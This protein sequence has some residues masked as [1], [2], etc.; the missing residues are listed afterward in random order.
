MLEVLSRTETG[1][2]SESA[3]HGGLGI[4]AFAALVDRLGPFAAAVG[5]SLAHLA[6][7]GGAGASEADRSAVGPAERRTPTALA[8]LRSGIEQVD[9]RIIELIGRRVEL[10]RGA[11][12]VKREAGL[13]V[14]DE[15][16]EHDVLARVR[17]LATSAGLPYDELHALQAYLIEISRRAQTHPGHP[18]PSP[19]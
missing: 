3:S 11:G 5:R 12:R 6:P 7:S 9:R 13:P 2:D 1:A 17:A 14:I 4:D 8:T 10:A 15:D 16:Q 18:S 19:D